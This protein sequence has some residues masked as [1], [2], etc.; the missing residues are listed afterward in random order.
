M[1]AEQASARHVGVLLLATIV[2]SA[3]SSAPLPSAQSE[4]PATLA[5]DA[6]LGG[7]PAHRAPAATLPSGSR[8]PE[9]VPGEAIVKLRPRLTK[10]QKDR[11][12]D[13]VGGTSRR[14]FRS[15]AEHW[16]LEKGLSVEEAIERLRRD[17]DVEYAEP[18]YVVRALSTP[19]DPYFTQLWGLHN[20]GQDGG[21]AGADIRATSAW[22]VSTGSRSVV[23]GV[24][25][26]GVDYNHPD[27]AANIFV[28]PYEIAGN[29]VDD[30]A[31]GFVDD[32]RGWDFVNN[33][34]DPFD[35]AGHGTH[36]AGTI[37]AVGNNS[38]GVV[39]VSW[40]VTI[41]PIKFLDASG[42][43]TTADATAAVDY[44]TSLGARITNN[45]WGGG[46]FSQALLDAIL[47]SGEAGSLFVA[48]AGND[49]GNTDLGPQYP[50]AYEAPNI[51]SVAA[52]DR[53]DAL[54]EFSNFGS[55]TVDLGAPGVDIQ[56]TRPGASYGEAS[57]TSMAAP[58]V[59]G[60]AVLVLATAPDLNAAQ[61]KQL[62]LG[63]TDPVPALAGITVTGGRLNAFRAIAVPET[64]PPGGVSNLA[65]LSG[66][67]YSLTLGW[68]ATGDDGPI[69]TAAAY[70][71]RYASSP[72]DETTFATATRAEP[73]PRPLPSGS[74]E[75]AE[76]KGL[77][78]GTTYYFALKAI[79]EWGQAGPMSNLASGTTLGPPDIAVQPASLDVQVVHGEAATRSLTLRN[80]GVGHLLFS[81]SMRTGG[82]VTLQGAAAGGEMGMA[83]ASPGQLKI[84]FLNCGWSLLTLQNH[85]LSFPDVASVDT[86]DFR[87]AVRPTVDDLLRYDAVAV[88]TAAGCGDLSA[89]GDMLADYAD[90][91]GGVVLNYI[92][93]YRQFKVAGRFLRDNYHP[94]LASTFGGRFSSLGS[95]DQAHPI[96]AGVR[97]AEGLQRYVTP[98]PGAQIVASW[99]T[100]YPFV[101]T[102]GNNVASININNVQAGDWTG[103]IPLVLHNALVWTRHRVAWASL[104]S[105]SG[106]VP[107]GDSL[108]LTLRFDADRLEP[109]D[110]SVDLLIDS[111]DPDEPRVAVPIRM[112]VT[113]APDIVLRGGE[114]L[115]E[116]ARDYVTSNAWT[117][118]S[119]DVPVL[120]SGSG[121]IDLIA[122]GDFSGDEIGESAFL[123]TDDFSVYGQLEHTGADCT[124][125]VLSIP[126]DSRQMALLTADGTVKVEVDNG[127]GTDAGCAVNRHTVRLRFWGPAEMLDFGRTFIQERKTLRLL[128][129][130]AGT[131]PLLLNGIASDSPAFVTGATSL[132]VPPGESRPLEVTFTPDGPEPSEGTLLLPSNDPD[133]P[134]LRMGLRG[135]G[136]MKPDIGVDP[137]SLDVA[138]DSG[139][140]T[141]RTLRIEN[142]GGSELTF[143]VDVHRAGA[144]NAAH[145][146]TVL[147]VEDRQPFGP[148][149]SNERVLVANGLTYTTINS[150]RLAATD[151]SAYG[152]VI[153]AGD[154][155]ASFYSTLAAQAAQL[156]DYVYAGGILEF[157]AGGNISSIGFLNL[158][159][160][161]GG[162]RL[163]PGFLFT[164]EIVAPDHPLLAELASP[165]RLAPSAYFTGLPA[166]AEVVLQAEPGKPVLAVYRHG[167]GAVVTG[168][169]PLDVS[170]SNP[171]GGEEQILRSMIPYAHGLALDWLSLQETAGVLQPGTGSDVTVGFDAS[172]RFAGDYEVDL[173]VHSDDP[174]EG[175]TVVPVRLRIIGQPDIDVAQSSLDFGDVFL[176]FPNTLTV[177]VRN[178]GIAAL[179]VDLTTGSPFSVS[180]THLEVPPRQSRPVA[181]TFDPMAPGSMPGALQLRTNDADEA[182]LT[183][184]LA[185]TGHIPE[186]ELRLP[187]GALEFGEVFIG[188]ARTLS[189]P[190]ANDG[191]ASL[192]VDL[193]TDGPF[194]VDPTHLVVPPHAGRTA[195]VTFSPATPGPVQGALHVHSNDADEADLTVALA[196]TGRPRPVIT[197]TPVALESTVIEGSNGSRVLTI[198]NTG[199]EDLTFAISVIISNPLLPRWLSV[200]PAAGVVPPGGRNDLAV[201]FDTAGLAPAI[202]LADLVIVTNDPVTPVPF[203][204]ATLVV[205]GDRDHDLIID[206]IDNCPDKSNP[207]QEDADLDRRGDGCDNCATVVNPDQTDSNGD[208]SGDACQPTLVL[209]GARQDGGLNLEIRAEFADPQQEPL[210]G[211]LAIRGA[212]S[213]IVDDILLSFDCSQGFLSDGTRG[214]GIGFLNGTVGEPVLVDLDYVFGCEDGTADFLMAPGDCSEPAGPFDIG[215]SL[216]SLSLPA[217]ICIRD[218]AAVDGGSTLT[219]AAFTLDTLTLV[220]YNTERFAVDF[221][222]GVPRVTDLSGLD[223]GA[224]FNLAMMVT[225]GTT[226]PVTAELPFLYQGESR[227]VFNSPPVAALQ[228]PA[229]SECDRPAGAQVMLDAGGSHDVDSTGGSAD[230][231]LAFEWFLNPGTTNEQPLGS[232]LQ[233]ATTLPLGI[234]QVGLRVTDQFGETG[235]A[236]TSVSVVDTAPPMLACPAPGIAEC[237]SPAGAP[238]VALAAVSDVCDP[239]PRIDNN[240][241]Q[242]GADASGIY[243]LGATGVTF[244]TRDGS[245]NKATCLMNVMVQDTA[246]PALQAVAGPAMLW[247]PNHSL[248]P[249][250]VDLAA[251]D[252][253]DP[254]VAPALVAV[255]N[256]EPD[257]APG[258][259]DGDTTGDI[260]G[261]DLGTAD[262]DLLL[263]AERSSHGPGRHYDLAY[264]AADASGNSVL[265]A[266]RVDV[267]HDMGGSTEPLVMTVE[268]VSSDGKVRLAWS[269]VPGALG[270]DVISGPLEMVRMENGVLRLGTVSVLARGTDKTSFNE[271]QE[272]MLPQPGRAFFYLIQQRTAAGGAGYGT[273]SAPWPREPAAC[274]GGC[275]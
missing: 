59:A 155:P 151:L 6:G 33:D 252:L 141:S 37:G 222:G 272:G 9:T 117:A 55:T 36:V 2:L 95:F 224:D 44:A 76:V 61:V 131:D 56:S 62:L 73:A 10:A 100:G 142:A 83:N 82:G 116:S 240:R 24:I 121:F 84:G 133:E 1:R 89:M 244:T 14:K 241:T 156:D 30:D 173:V 63:A 231:I 118:H 215:L 177:Q 80:D 249:V 27:L 40:T 214:P 223:P 161:P 106:V 26:T 218:S 200:F 259:G 31:N 171:P 191:M 268:H 267:A 34:N 68:T 198:S 39:G 51:I 160:L 126:V 145:E 107:P 42:A 91:G 212:E 203:V 149:Q 28:N 97:S 183:V 129:E 242:A 234:S 264:R 261:A 172:R 174:D 187:F 269:P 143:E 230:D 53:N 166:D 193:A 257:N 190:I 260:S 115:L 66:T 271:P 192:Q 52:T 119:F 219:I 140:T 19:D 197:L 90:A 158:V 227:L 265:T 208:G 4:N 93:F 98:T 196:G 13:R 92:S 153:V 135:Q 275:P 226:V 250:H 120:P 253:C 175:K 246:P 154:Q 77:A 21:T 251:H 70:D 258:M 184:A 47:E 7:G 204:R 138:L 111:N 211:R 236:E 256:S 178:D 103:D 229:S 113:G 38:I 18:N 81:T 235:L 114:I 148:T 199:T 69:G 50:S 41:V 232:G 176:G 74:P 136:R 220:T 201:T 102:K 22:D 130:N 43:G 125:A 78:L 270:Y 169:H 105:T 170:F 238:V 245:G 273:E 104:D 20:A 167:N 35:D 57:G 87:S 71:I 163:E 233:I 228:A 25:D 206:A 124:P 23:V 237:T 17:P 144:G 221:E 162:V 225:D 99:M 205:A 188:L 134:E 216:A 182:E 48:A 46:G 12:K 58:H 213:V 152:L 5:P 123:S 248:R 79:D 202:Y 179:I 72:I 45:S 8:E 137:D 112:S 266:A 180:P 88:F 15:G 181:V 67:S 159:V 75:Q 147:L 64:I 86:L 146:A 254:A 110:R 139:E 189:V 274:G 165:L 49:G 207:L 239:A 255:T 263:R 128:V 168:S 32:V 122:E 109:G 54:A 16:R 186:P 262:A 157:H 150:G 96:M 11:V 85:L 108:D 3:V 60:A 194:A 65:V 217:K 94:F 210:S 247:P 164:L 29:G 101:A 243:P 127:T 185:G 209:R 132:L 195:I